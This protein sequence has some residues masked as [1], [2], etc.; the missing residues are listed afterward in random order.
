MLKDDLLQRL[1]RLDEDVDLSIDGNETF[2]LVLVGGGALI[3]QEYIRR[4]THDLDAISVSP[5]IMNLLEK[6]DINCRVQTYINNFPYNF[7]DRLIPLKLDTKRI[8][9]DTVS[10]EDIV[11][12]K[13]YSYN[14]SKGC[15]DRYNI[16]RSGLEPSRSTG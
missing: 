7:E 2:H 9:F 16:V 12:A 13:L 6:Y 10:L 3:L 14:R 11:I 4:A 15:R 1:Y 8:R 5:R